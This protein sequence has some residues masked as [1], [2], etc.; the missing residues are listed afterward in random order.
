MQKFPDFVPHFAAPQTLK[1]P[2]RDGSQIIYMLF[3]PPIDGGIPLASAVE[4]RQFRSHRHGTLRATRWFQW[5]HSFLI[6]LGIAETF[7]LDAKWRRASKAINRSIDQSAMRIAGHDMGEDA[8]E[9][10]GLSRLA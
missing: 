6:L 9:P 10:E 7:G 2:M 5:C 3:H 1:P 4:S 8:A